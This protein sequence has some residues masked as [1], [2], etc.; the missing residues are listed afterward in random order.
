M[1]AVEQS[2]QERAKASTRMPLPLSVGGEMPL[3]PAFQGILISDLAA[4]HYQSEMLKE[5][6]VITER[7]GVMIGITPGAE[8]TGATRAAAAKEAP[9]PAHAKDVVPTVVPE[10]R[11]ASPAHEGDVMRTA[12]MDEDMLP[13]PA[14]GLDY[15][16]AATYFGTRQT[17]GFSLAN[18]RQDVGAKM[19]EK[20]ANATWG[21]QITQD[22]FGRWHDPA[23]G[24]FI[25]AE[26]PAVTSFLKREAV[27]LSA[28]GFAK[29][30]AAGETVG[31]AGAGA[32]ARAPGGM[33][34]LR[35][36]GVA[37][38]AAHVADMALDFTVNQRAA[39]AEW[40]RIMGGTNLGGI[41]ERI[42]SQAFGLFSQ[43]GGMS[44][45]EAEKL[46][47]GVAR[48][49][50]RGTDR[51]RAQEFAQQNYRQFG[52]TVDQS[53]EIVNVAARTG[54]ESLMG[55]SNALRNVTE[56]AQ[57]AGVNTEVARQRFV[58]TYVTFSETIG[59]RAAV[60]TAAGTTGALT[61]MGREFQNVTPEIGPNQLRQYAAMM[62]LPSSNALRL[63]AM[64]PGQEG[65]IGEAQARL[66]TQRVTAM[67]RRGGEAAIAPFRQVLASGRELSDA[68][69]NQLTQWALTYGPQDVNTM[70]TVLSGLGFENVT[71]D[72]APLL[73]AQHYLEEYNPGE[74]AAAAAEAGA[75]RKID[76][77][78]SGKFLAQ[79]ESAEFRELREKVQASDT[80]RWGIGERAVQDYFIE[81]V[82]RTG[83]AGGIAEIIATDASVRAGISQVEV[84]GPGGRRIKV[85][86]P[87]AMRDYMD[88]INAGTARVI[89][90]EGDMGDIGTFVGGVTG[91]G[92]TG[93]AA[94][95]G[96]GGKVL[97]DA[98]PYLRSLI[99]PTSTSGNVYVDPSSLWEPPPSQILPGD[100]ATGEG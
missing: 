98:T 59:G 17:G 2:I 80:N 77:S 93:A 46:Y 70:I 78:T 31:Q 3:S 68:E 10:G 4:A 97:F 100:R 19:E 74:A 1:G 51:A 61:G 15:G 50:M 39:N 36:A 27:M 57:E 72:N 89:G 56:S 95:T 28:R 43:F 20:L 40:Q 25:S 67:T 65:I 18:L 81:N 33:A 64:Q 16:R 26:D 66:A 69:K 48:T 5:L 30:L 84:E 85:G 55:L 24:R 47:L 8:P 82:K 88:Q 91:A 41:E 79:P 35:F 42:R 13:A 73:W 90:E 34:A 99:K 94:A 83:Q 29:S 32:L 54:Q 44:S 37:V 92:V 71:A 12:A 38:G 87:E 76:V 75:V 96:T 23:T 14:H 9:P 62:G 60:T 22:Q 45:E 52:M 11:R 58:D 49:G 86:L 53:M 21:T 63:L 6:R 7:L